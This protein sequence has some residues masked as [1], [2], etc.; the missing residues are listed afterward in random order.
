M[1]WSML[2]VDLSL[3]ETLSLFDIVECF[4]FFLFPKV[5]ACRSKSPCR[6]S[7]S[8]FTP[9]FFVRDESTTKKVTTDVVP[10]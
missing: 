8:Q 5:I 7:L 1:H 6:L 2:S 10:Q 4:F 9:Y 3:T